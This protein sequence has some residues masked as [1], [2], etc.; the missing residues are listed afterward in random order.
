[1]NADEGF[2]GKGFPTYQ[3]TTEERRVGRQS[4]ADFRACV[5]KGFPTY[6]PTTE[7]RRVGRQSFADAMKLPG[8]QP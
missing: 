1:M 7:E 8:A 3:P 4:F 6:Q 5:G 2:V